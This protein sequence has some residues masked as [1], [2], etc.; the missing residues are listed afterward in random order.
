MLQSTQKQLT[1]HFSFLK[2][3]NQ[4][5]SMLKNKRYAYDKHYTLQSD[6]TIWS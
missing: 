2:I 1:Y 6:C 5:S 4:I 3:E